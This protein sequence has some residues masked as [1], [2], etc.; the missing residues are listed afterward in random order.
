MYSD[1]N[2]YRD[3]PLSI[4]GYKSCTLRDLI[5][6]DIPNKAAIGFTNAVSVQ[7]RAFRANITVEEMAKLQNWDIYFVND[8]TCSQEG[9]VY[10]PATPGIIGGVQRS[11]QFNSDYVG[12]GVGVVSNDEIRKNHPEYVHAQGFGTSNSEK[13]CIL[14]TGNIGIGTINPS[15][16]LQLYNTG[17]SEIKILL[18]DGS[19]GA[20]SNNGFA[21]YKSSTNDGYI[22]N[23]TNNTLR[24]GTNNAERMCI[25]SNGNVGIGTDNPN[26][27][28]H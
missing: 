6:I 19:T 14:E 27:L 16:L 12:N 3:Q 24:F 7:A 10:H 18:T 2:T 13:M 8:V 5:N 1:P 23:Y 17:T 15:S 25:S 28:L 22:W 21:I 4:P 26:S 20:L 11:R 9:H